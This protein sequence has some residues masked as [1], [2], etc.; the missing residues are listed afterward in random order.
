M[1]NFFLQIS[2]MFFSEDF[3]IERD[4]YWAVAAVAG[5]ILENVF[6]PCLKIPH[7]EDYCKL[8]CHVTK[9]GALCLKQRYC[10]LLERT[11]GQEPGV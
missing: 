7:Q 11:L 2:K 8:Y 4:Y 10:G 1:T 9:P 3:S 6:A 5:G